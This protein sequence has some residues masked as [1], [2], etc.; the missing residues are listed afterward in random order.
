MKKVL[1]QRV[2]WMIRNGESLDNVA[3]GQHGQ[4]NH[5]T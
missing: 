4:Q 5:K 3:D 2:G 1:G